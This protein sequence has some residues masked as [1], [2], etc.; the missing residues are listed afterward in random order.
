[1]AYSQKKYPIDKDRI[2]QAIKKAGKRAAD[3]S[4]NA[5][6]CREWITKQ[7]SLGELTKPAKIALEAAGILYA[8][9]APLPE[10]GGGACTA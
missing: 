8:D 5:G 10:N 7:I 1:M 6:Y 2:Q 9:C 4:E 3:I